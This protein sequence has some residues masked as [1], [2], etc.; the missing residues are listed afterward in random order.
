[1]PEP[2][3]RPGPT[4]AALLRELRDLLRGRGVGRLPTE[5]VVAALAGRPGGPVTANRLGRM[6]RPHGVAPRQYRT[7]GSGRRVW[8]YLLADLPESRDTAPPGESRDSADRLAAEQ[9][10]AS[11]MA[12]AAACRWGR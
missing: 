5:E 8:G 7:P 4:T 1:M 3:S 12:M 10:W 11:R 6:L 9:E 2:P